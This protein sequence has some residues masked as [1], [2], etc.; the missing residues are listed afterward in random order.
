MPE[1]LKGTEVAKALR[2]ELEVEAQ[3]LKAR[4]VQPCGCL[5][6]VGERADDIQYENG[7]A[8]TFEKLGIRVEKRSFAS[9]VSQDELIFA[10]DKINADPLIHGVLIFQPL[11]N[12]LDARA[13]RNRLLPCKDVD[14]MTDLSTIGV[15]R[16]E[17]IGYAPCTAQACIELLDHYKIDVAGKNAVVIGRSNI[18]G[19]PLSLLLL[20]RNATVTLCHSKTRNLREV[21]KAADILFAAIG[22]ARMID[23]DYVSS[24][25][26]VIDVG[27]NVLKDGTVCG[28]VNFDSVAPIVARL[29]P[30]PRGVG[31]ITTTVL[32]KNILSAAGRTL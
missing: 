19:K 7:A 17:P 31:S 26:T 30:V 29:T 6:R 4:G 15:Y 14:G 18:V 2:A 32:A 21:C 12:H 10:I 1:I 9:D 27:I 20:H 16:N 23:S 22:R 25:Q 3:T 5:I 8:A 13:I 28:D 24:G 11:P